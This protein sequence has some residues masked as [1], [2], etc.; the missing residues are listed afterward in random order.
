MYCF[1]FPIHDKYGQYLYGLT[2]WLYIK[3]LRAK[4]K[5]NH[6]LLLSVGRVF[7]LQEIPNSYIFPYSTIDSGLFPSEVITHDQWMQL[8]PAHSSF[9]GWMKG[10]LRGKKELQDEPLDQKLKAI[11]GTA[12]MWDK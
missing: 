6:Y 9:S 12:P 10:T 5:K 1:I 3:H 2:V 7:K 8:K 11:L 4:K